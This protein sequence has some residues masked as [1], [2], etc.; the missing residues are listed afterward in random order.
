M[1]P[2]QLNTMTV[3]QRCDLQKWYQTQYPKP[4]QKATAAWFLDKYGFRIT[5]S[6]VS[7]SLSQRFDNI[8]KADQSATVVQRQQAPAWPKLEAILLEQQRVIKSQGGCTSTKLLQAQARKIWY[9]IPEN[10]GIDILVF[11]NGWVT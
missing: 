7:E 10:I 11:S 6:T 5:Q 2:R 4:T 3:D 9:Q 8:D 1:A